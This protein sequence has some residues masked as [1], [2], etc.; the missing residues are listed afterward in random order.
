[1]S[2]TRDAFDPFKFHVDWDALGRGWNPFA[3]RAALDP[4]LLARAV[5]A[6]MERCTLRSADGSKLVWNRYDVIVEPGARDHLRGLERLIASQLPAAIEQA[7]AKLKAATVGP[8]VVH[9]LP[10]EGGTLTSREAVVRVKCEAEGEAGD[11]EGAI[12]IRLS[13]K[14]KGAARS[15]ILPESSSVKVSWPQGEAIVPEGQRVTFGRA[16]ENPPAT[17]IA[18]TG[19]TG[20]INSRQVWIE[21]FSG[22]VSVGRLSGANPVQVEGRE[23]Q[24]GGHIQVAQLPV[25][26]SLSLGELTLRVEA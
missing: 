18:L 16:H 17:F 2:V 19:A 23:V 13:R 1:M 6:V 10:D 22:K 11:P 24:P 20:K 4:H 5:S 15:S 7:R 21:L 14:P 25:D 3:R 26:I 9:I 8:F 12:T